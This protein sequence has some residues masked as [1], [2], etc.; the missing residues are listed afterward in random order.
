MSKKSFVV[1]I[2]SLLLLPSC[3]KEDMS[4]CPEQ[5]RIYF[6]FTTVDTYTGEGNDPINPEDVDR[7]HV[8][9]F[10][11]KGYYLGEY[12]DDNITDFST[13]YFIDCSDLLPG[14]YRF[15]AWGGKD[16]DFYMTVPE[17]FVKG[18][19]TF[20]KAFLLLKHPEN[21]ITRLVHHIFHSDLPATV[22][23]AKEQRFDMPLAQ[24]S[25]T[26]NLYTIG[27]PPDADDYTFT[28]TDNNDIYDFEN[29]FA[30]YASA[31]FFTY[32]APCT[33]DEAGQLRSTLHVLRM[34]ED[35][36]TPTLQI[37]NETTGELLYP[38]DS[39]P[40]NLI[41]LIN[42]AC[43]GNDFDKKHT[44]DITLDFKDWGKP[45]GTTVTI[46]INGWVVREEEVTLEE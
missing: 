32:N 1:L 37:K 29:S 14:G 11:G 25:N 3:I 43:P 5:I 28:I 39:Y 33:R 17:P 30:S 19:T 13:E 4:N 15:V 35:R 20:D 8:Y 41:N 9:V 45:T 2:V 10:D 16:E 36:H 12:R 31:P 24:M 38:F 22:T 34:A 46:M 42:S 23:I 6:T 18:E 7:M 26:I 21:R 27:L 44:Y 40:N